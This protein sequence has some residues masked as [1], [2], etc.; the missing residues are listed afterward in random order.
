[1]FVK[2]ISKAVNNTQLSATA[3]ALLA[4]VSVATATGFISGNTSVVRDIIINSNNFDSI[5]VGGVAGVSPDNI[6]ATTKFDVFASNDGINYNLVKSTELVASGLFAVIDITYTQCVNALT[7]ITPAPPTAEELAI[8]A[9]DKLR[10]E[11]LK[12]R[13]KLGDY[14]TDDWRWL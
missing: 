10:A 12:A 7:T 8:I 13:L 14:I 1:M 6:L 11:Q 2:L 3:T 9:A 4:G 5:R